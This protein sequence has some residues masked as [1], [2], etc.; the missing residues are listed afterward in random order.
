MLLCRRISK[1][2]KLGYLFS[3]TYVRFPGNWQLQFNVVKQKMHRHII[4]CILIF[5]H[6]N[7][8]HSLT[9]GIY[10]QNSTSPKFRR[11]HLGRMQVHKMRKRK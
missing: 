11:K 10:M 1:G 7:T 9:G 8:L 5:K 6:F 2:I 3:L 4:F